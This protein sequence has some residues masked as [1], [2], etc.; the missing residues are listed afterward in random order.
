M[1]TY[2]SHYAPAITIFTNMYNKLTVSHSHLRIRDFVRVSAKTP[3]APHFL[4]LAP[5]GGGSLPL[6]AV[7]DAREGENRLKR[8]SKSGV[9][10]ERVEREGEKD[11]QKRKKWGGGGGGGRIERKKKKWGNR[12]S[13]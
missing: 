4:V 10:T 2:V 11:G 13:K 8:V 6:E 7:P 12:V 5:G 1:K 9:S 3:L